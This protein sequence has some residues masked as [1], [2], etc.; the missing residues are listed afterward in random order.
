MGYSAINTAKN[1]VSSIVTLVCRFLK[2]VFE[3]KPSLSKYKKHLGCQCCPVIVKPSPTSGFNSED[4]TCK[5]TMLLA[6]LPGLICQ[7]LHLLSVRGM[8]L[9]HNSCVF[10]IHKRL[11]ASLPGEHVS[12]L[13]LTAYS[14]GNRLC[15]IVYLSD[16]VMRT[17]EFRKA[18][19][20]LLVS[21]QK[22]H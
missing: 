3:L 5:T 15:P 8:V 14:A 20:Q 21:F 6:L 9:K 7:T 18:S 19:D 11:K 17:S 12:A 2:G 13:T 4:L 22:P 1:V 16:Y 10:T